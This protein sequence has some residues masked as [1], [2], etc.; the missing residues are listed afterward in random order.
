MRKQSAKQKGGEG[1]V[2]VGCVE[3]YCE[4]L[5][6]TYKQMCLLSRIN[7]HN[8][9]KVLNQLLTQMENSIKND[10]KVRIEVVFLL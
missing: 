6:Q 8:V 7:V 3:S 4:Q 9:Q 5:Y 1:F 2:T 10:T